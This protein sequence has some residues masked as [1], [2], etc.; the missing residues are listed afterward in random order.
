EPGEDVAHEIVRDAG[1][2]AARDE[3]VEVR[4]LA[5]AIE[6]GEL[7]IGLHARDLAD[8][9]HAL[10]EEIDDLGVFSRELVAKRDELRALRLRHGVRVYSFL[11]VTLAP[12]R[13]SS[14]A[15]RTTRSPSWRSPS[16][17][18][19]SPIDEPRVTLT[20]RTEAPSTR[21]TNVRSVDCTIALGATKR[22]GPGRRTGQATSANSPGASLRDALSTSSSTGIVR[23]R[24]SSECELRWIFAG[25]VSPGQQFCASSSVSVQ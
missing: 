21:R 7:R 25:K 16:T 11:T 13:S 18:M 15:W 20:R 9:A 2:A 1:V 17:S 5:L 10:G 12:S 22:L 23:V 3:I 6:R 24:G 19:R 14:L 4:A 8:Y